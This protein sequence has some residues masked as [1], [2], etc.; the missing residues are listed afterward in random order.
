MRVALFGSPSFA[1]PVLEA[2]QH[3]HDLLLVVSQPDKK[4]GRGM[5]VTPPATAQKAQ[6]LG[7]PLAQP[8]KLKGNQAFAEQLRALALDVA[9][10]AAYGKILPAA[11][12][13][14]PRH[15]FLNIHASL[16][17]QYRGAAPIQWALISGESETG[18]SIM[19]T[20]IGMDTGAVRLQRRIP[21]TSDDDALS[22]FDKLALL[23]AQAMLEALEQLE[24]GKLAS[25]PQDS[26]AASYAPLLSKDDGRIRWHDPA[27][28]IL[29]RHRGVIAYP[30]SWTQW[31][32]KRL[33]V[34]RM[35]LADETPTIS[36]QPGTLLSIADDALLFATSSSG[37]W[38]EQLTPA[39]KAPMD[40][41]A[42]ARGYGLRPGDSLAEEVL[43][44]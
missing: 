28:A 43:R 35:R 38:L 8:A 11:L 20:D 3:Q 25:Y 9:I 29:N 22:L 19:Q 2:L 7:I 23:G 16:L 34:N 40:A 18:V 27:A 31:Q 10:T 37:L 1:L 41:A 15:G 32:G 13:D 21:I 26:A 24:T 36:A 14:V 30:G 17:P 44:G 6:S 12:L 5:R 42:W 33:K 39:G 4:A